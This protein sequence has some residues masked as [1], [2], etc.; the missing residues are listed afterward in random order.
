MQSLRMRKLYWNVLKEASGM[1]T[2]NIAMST[3]EQYLK[4][5]N[6]PADPFYTPDVKISSILTSGMKKLNLI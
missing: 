4:A 1:K 3:F 2:R 6:N 5:V